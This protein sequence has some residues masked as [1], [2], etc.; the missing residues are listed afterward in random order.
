M[1]FTEYD[2]KHCQQGKTVEVTLSGN[3]ANV[4]LLDSV[5]LKKYKNGQNPKYFGGNMT[6]SISQIRI[7]RT[8]HWYVV[9]DLGGYTGNVTSKVR[10]I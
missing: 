2:L 10:V 9:I 7:P 5:N 1:K 6:S 8:G 4:L 3:A